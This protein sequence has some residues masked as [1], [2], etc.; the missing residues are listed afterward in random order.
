MNRSYAVQT[1]A[2]YRYPSHPSPFHAK[3]TTKKT[4]KRG[5][6]KRE[7]IVCTLHYIYLSI[8]HPSITTRFGRWFIV[9]VHQSSS[10]S[11]PSKKENEKEK[12]AVEP[13]GNLTLTLNPEPR[14]ELPLY[15][16]PCQ[17]P[18]KSPQI[19]DKTS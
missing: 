14:D 17:T 3:K 18:D 16:Y 19:D 15:A 10:E 12:F 9:F 11:K 13:E 8:P 6:N 4:E 2:P 5:T 7:Y 1:Y